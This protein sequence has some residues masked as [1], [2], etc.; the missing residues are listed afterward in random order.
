LFDLK[1]FDNKCNNNNFILL[2]EKSEIILKFS[3]NIVKNY[4]I[5]S[6]LYDIETSH[7]IQLKNMLDN[8]ISLYSKYEKYDNSIVENY[9]IYLEKNRILNEAIYN[10][11]IISNIIEK[12]K[13]KYIVP[14][15]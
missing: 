2:D 14:V 15:A 5:F 10:Q 13:E 9:Y 4:D 6:K 12:R 3:L 7:L 11:A 1:F 8:K